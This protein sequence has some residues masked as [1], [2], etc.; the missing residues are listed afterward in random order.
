MN[1]RDR[2]VAIAL[3]A[4]IVLAAGGFLFY[5]LY[6]VPLDER[7]A[8]L[9][10]TQ[11][12][13]DKL[14]ERDEKATRQE[15][16][17]EPWR[18][19]SLPRD[20]ELSQL[21]YDR[22]LNQLM[23][24]CR[25]V[26]F[27]VK[28]AAD[29]A[30]SYSGGVLP[31]PEKKETPPYQALN[32]TVKGRGDLFQVVQLLEEFY[33][34]PLLHRIRKLTIRRANTGMQPAPHPK[35]VAAVQRRQELDIEMTVEAIIVSGA[36]DRKEL[37]PKAEAHNLAPGRKYLA[38][39]RKD[40]FY[41]PPPPPQ[42]QDGPDPAQKVRLTMITSDSEHG[43]KAVLYD[44]ASKSIC[45]LCPKTGHVLFSIK[46]KMG[47]FELVQID[48]AGHR[49]IFSADNKLYALPVEQTVADALRRPLSM[50]QLRALELTRGPGGKEAQ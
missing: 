19:L 3:L 12:A 50:A 20:K 36:E 8:D 21:D 43:C 31:S 7:Q 26:D 33:R 42:K 4:G 18:R 47:Q 40:P 39:T 37:M 2:M 23:N 9:D 45:Y 34:T 30:Y 27:D 1:P 49:I 38:I 29:T 17:L 11:D 25:F 41:P 48:E 5:E 46:G 44:E 22:F 13:I 16:E 35:S 24:K 15:K 6:L 10:A 28:K 32:F 14:T